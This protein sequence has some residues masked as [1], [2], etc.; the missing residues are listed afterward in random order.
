M[1]AN[2]LYYLAYY[3]CRYQRCGEE[4]EGNGHSTQEAVDDL[5]GRVEEHLVN[6]HKFC[7][8][9]AGTIAKAIR[10]TRTDQVLEPEPDQ[11]DSKHGA[12]K[13]FYRFP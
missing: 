13:D 3:I 2:V 8:K 4:L 7:K 1:S 11:K 12:Y 10:P 5:Q 9:A 6:M